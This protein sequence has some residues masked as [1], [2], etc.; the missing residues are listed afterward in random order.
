MPGKHKRMVSCFWKAL[1]SDVENDVYIYIT[2][3]FLCCN[4]CVFFSP[5]VCLYIRFH[6]DNE[7]D[8]DYGLPDFFL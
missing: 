8:D 6:K 5:L 2:H 3:F 7:T 1:E 4:C